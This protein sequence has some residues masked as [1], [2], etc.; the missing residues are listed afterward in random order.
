MRLTLSAVLL[1]LGT[2]LLALAAASAVA[3]EPAASAELS[4]KDLKSVESHTLRGGDEPQQ[5]VLDVS[6]MEGLVLLAS[7]YSWGQAVWGEAKLLAADGK[8]TKLADLEPTSFRVGWGEFSKNHGPDQ[9]P[10][11]VGSREFLHGLFAHADSEVVYHLGRK[12]ARFEAWVGV[13][14]TAQKNGNI[15]LK[16]ADGR[17]AEFYQRLETASLNFT[18]ERLAGFRTAIEQS[19]R[20][21]PKDPAKLKNCLERLSAWENS[22]ASIRGKLDQRL[23]SVLKETDEYQRLHREAMT[24]VLQTCLDAP[25]LFVK[26]HPYMSAHIYDE[27]L[28]WH[29]GGGIYILENP[30]AP[31]EQQIVRP[32]IDPKT[33]ETLGEGV[34][35][36]PEISYDG[37]RVLFAF[38]GKSNGDTCIFEIGV[39]GT[40]LRRLTD[41][42]HDCAKKERPAGLIGDGQHDVK[43]CYLPDGR[44]AFT[45]TRTGAQVMCFSSYIDILHTMNPD[46]SDLK[47]ISVNNQN[48]F[49]PIVM[50]DGRILYGRWEYVDKTALYMQSL[51]TV[52]PDGTFER[53]LFKNNLAKPTAVL[54]ARPVPGTDL[55][56]AA[57]TPHNGQ[58]VGAIGMID[59]RV[60]KNKLDAITNFT[61][62][63]PKE[64][65]QGL[66]RGPCDPWPLSKDLVLIANNADAHGP[67]GVIE[68]L[69]RYGMRVVLRKEP[70]IS[71]YSPML[72]KPHPRPP[73]IPSALKPGEPATF[74]VRDIYQ[75]LKGVQRGE[76][77]WLRVI[78]TTARISG[79][80]PGGRWWNQAFLVSWQGSYDIKSFLG[81]VPVAEDGSAYFEAPP[82]KALYF[83][84]LDKDGKLVQSMRT[85]V[86]SAPGVTRS[87]VG[88]HIED[89]DV[90]PPNGLRPLALQTRPAQITPES[91]GTGFID[92]PTMVQPILDKHCVSCHGGEKGIEAGLD[93]SGGWTWAFNISYETLI[94][95]TLS[96]FLNCE[97][98]SVK[99]AEILLPRVHGSASAPLTK[100]VLKGDRLSAKERSLLLAW[101][102]GNCNY[103]GTWNYTPY[104]TC[105]EIKNVRDALLPEM[106]MASCTDCHQKEIGN[107]WVNLQD[108]ERSRMLRAPLAKDANGL[109]LAWCRARK[110]RGIDRPPVF[111]DHQPPDVFRPHRQP[112]PNP[113]G[114]GKTPFPNT[115]DPSY[116]AMLDIIRNAREAA[117][118]TPRVDM[119][120]AQTIQGHCRQLAPLTPPMPMSQPHAAN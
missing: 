32:V 31:P 115:A 112:A 49:D 73:V 114:L 53:A 10:L 99:T 26:R 24:E 55:V 105:N 19:L 45:S 40:G 58:S 1:W 88:C 111:G 117:L 75:G 93:F 78:E 22:F 23:L 81:V 43:P 35:S 12:Y 84:A 98:G 2:G 79:L 57:L 54:D 110:A 14:A 113:E 100:Q 70:D 72:V 109:G 103:Y 118:K 66:S 56:V 65:D 15:K 83:Q 11:K 61:P 94:K 85:F 37:R 106:E 82:A 13:N 87:C 80:P 39:D 62:E 90:A 20:N 108:P 18:K 51:W 120:G 33:K 8:E 29:P 30:W 28:T 3:A 119:P 38:K 107:D 50:A 74:L 71:C 16:A 21:N 7:G 44:I 97:N 52:N 102:D 67:H 25:L 77:K 63:Y 4:L 104:A 89:E 101:M 42:G 34:Y 36:D 6:G 76:V 17:L 47:S 59:P 92:Y 41:P 64:M 116:Q 96:G 48:E 46:G 60:G 95:N 9:K 91:W 86:Q 27:Y 69:S 68:L 5:L